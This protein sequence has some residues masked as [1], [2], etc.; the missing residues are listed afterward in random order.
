[1][2]QA[3]DGLLC[4]AGSHLHEVGLVLFVFVGVDHSAPGLPQRIS[5]LQRDN[6]RSRKQPFFGLCF[7]LEG[8]AIDGEKLD[9]LRELVRLFRDRIL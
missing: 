2:R 5:H 6:A 4:H 3:L 9:A 1:M 8:L 7:I